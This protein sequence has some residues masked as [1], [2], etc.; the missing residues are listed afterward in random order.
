VESETHIADRVS[1]PHLPAHLYIHVPFCRVKCS[2]CD[3]YSVDDLDE[4]AIE[5][6]LLGVEAEMQT[7]RRAG[8]AGV[9]ETVYIG[10]GT[11]TVI[12]AGTV[13]LVRAAVE[14]FPVR[15]GSEITVEANPDSVT[16]ALMEA[17]AAAGATRV[18]L[19]VQSFASH[20]LGVL[21]RVHTADEA[22]RAADAVR[23]A[24]LGLSLDLM[25]GIPGQTA[26]SWTE[27]L[28]KAVSTGA[29][30]LSVYPLTLEEGTPLEVAVGTGLAP[31]PDSDA[32]AD[33]MV[34]AEEFL[35]LEG[36]DRY[37]TANYC[38]PGHECRHNVSYWTGRTYAGFG[39]AAH[40]M[41][42]AP[43]AGTIT[44][45]RVAGA[46]RARI[47]NP[48]DLSAWESGEE[49]QIEWLDGPSAAREDAML[50]LRM[51]RGIDE[52]TVDRADVRAVMEE[53]EERY[54]V[55]HVG[56][57]WWTTRKGW[58]LGNEVFGAVW[59]G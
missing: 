39:P 19:G 50:G 51:V 18:S 41:L 21:G 9:V 27:T 11:P 36:I 12:A 26:A 7:W 56:D 6:Y 29:E 31:E 44:G 49:P 34:M 28:E 13:R 43:T 46:V 20:E 58:L 22:A 16:P 42:D 4:T 54:L 24:G 14:R 47:A 35:S 32:T 1:E 38:R 59:G 25:C 5:S 52:H 10:G 17:L 45:Q 57:R 8:L 3:F 23:S 48:A 40:A 2:Y 30:H 37:E 15:A 33:L 55:E 53:L